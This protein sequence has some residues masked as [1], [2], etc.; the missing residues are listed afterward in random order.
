MV[1]SCVYSII[2]LFSCPVNRPLLIPSNIP[3][4]YL[5]KHFKFNSKFF[6]S[7]PVQ[8]FHCRLVFSQ[9]L[10]SL[11]LIE[12][13]L[14]LSTSLSAGLDPVGSDGPADSEGDGLPNGFHQSWYKN[15]DYFRMDGSSLGKSRQRWINEFNDVSD[16]R[17]IY[18]LCR[19]FFTFRIIFLIFIF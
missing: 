7:K 5:F 15:V 18:I 1:K 12:E 2:I 13:M 16:E 10:L 11:D 14:A 3:S 17:Y 8:L 9:S 19:D 6:P 4:Q